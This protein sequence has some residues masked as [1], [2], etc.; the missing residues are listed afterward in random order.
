L[1]RSGR[2][3]SLRSQ[4]S[5]LAPKLWRDLAAR[6]QADLE[7]Y[8]KRMSREKTEAIQ[9]ANGSLLRSLLPVI[10][11][12]DMGLTAAKNEDENSMIYRGM[13]MVYDQIQNFLTENKVDLIDVAPD[14]DFD[15]NLHEAIKQEP[16]D[17]VPEGKVIF[18]LRKGYQL[19][20]RLLRPANVVVSQ[21]PANEEEQAAE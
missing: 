21:G 1:F 14:S 18:T 17:S 5:R 10:D 13:A 8:R 16:S 20:D 9:Y 2:N 19:R 15:P 3:R 12:F 7:N 4:Q 6:N 11:N